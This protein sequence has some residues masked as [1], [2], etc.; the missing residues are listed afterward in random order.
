MLR[1]IVLTERL[2]AVWEI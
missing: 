1:D 2:L